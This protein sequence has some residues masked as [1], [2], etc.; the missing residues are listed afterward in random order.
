MSR[1]LFSAKALAEAFAGRPERRAGACFSG[2]FL[3]KDKDPACVRNEHV[4]F[5]VLVDIAG[6]DLRADAAI[7]IN[8]VCNEFSTALAVPLQLK[9]IQHGGRIR[10]LVLERT[11]R[12]AA[13][14][15]H[16]ILQAVAI[17]VGKL[18]GV[19]LG[20]LHALRVFLGS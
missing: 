1:K 3:R 20:E 14:S 13:F 18:H 5:A 4:D 10:L 6:G 9:P 7:F 16:Q 15:R 17:D 19:Q 11:V 2:L 12:P 8:E